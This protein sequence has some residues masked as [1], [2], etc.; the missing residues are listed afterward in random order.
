[1]TVLYIV[2]AIVLVLLV[3]IPLFL[4]SRVHC[5]RSIEI[6]A[7]SDKVFTHINSYQNWVNWSPWAEKDPEM[8]N[9]YTGPASGVG[10]AT[11]WTGNKKVGQGKMVITKSVP[12]TEMGFDLQFGKNPKMSPAGFHLKELNGKTTVTWYIDIDFGMFLPGRYFGLMFDK[13]LGPDYEKGLLNLKNLS[14]K[15]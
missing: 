8:K 1:M 6:N 14:E 2:L 13:I 4:P 11:S 5:E 9:T 10:N 15:N 7:S 12:S 3:L